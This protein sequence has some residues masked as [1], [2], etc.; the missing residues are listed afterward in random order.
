[1]PPMTARALLTWI[2]RSYWLALMICS[3]CLSRSIAEA[4]SDASSTAGTPGVNQAAATA[5]T[6]DRQ[7][8][9]LIRIKTYIDP[10]GLLNV[11][12]KNGQNKEYC[13]SWWGVTCGGDG[14]DNTTVTSIKITR[15]GG[16]QVLAWPPS[17]G[18][19]F[20]WPAGPARASHHFS[21]HQRHNTCIMGSAE[22][23]QMDRLEGQQADF[24]H[25]A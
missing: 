22:A 14:K 19:C 11:T 2:G 18:C 5:A 24:W 10:A 7:L 16:D 21:E 4:V 17:P 9:S 15:V 8:Q 25:P 23:A 1:M 13:K 3:C 20:C 6:V 12:W